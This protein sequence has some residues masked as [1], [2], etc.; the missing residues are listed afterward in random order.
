MKEK[1]QEIKTLKRYVVMHNKGYSYGDYDTTEESAEQIKEVIRASL[2]YPARKKE[3]KDFHIL[4]TYNQEMI[5]VEEISY[6]EYKVIGERKWE[7]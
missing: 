3:F 4:D 5:E 2:E 1:K 7:N 6:K